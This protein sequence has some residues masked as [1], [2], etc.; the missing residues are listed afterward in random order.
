MLELEAADTARRVG[1]AAES[2][3]GRLLNPRV[4]SLIVA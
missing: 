4:N 2:L 3:I 1:R